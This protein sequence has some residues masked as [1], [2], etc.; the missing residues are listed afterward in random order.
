MLS[1][2]KRAQSDELSADAK[3]A[4]KDVGTLGLS[5]IRSLATDLQVM[6]RRA[7]H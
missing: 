3:R 2:K 1:T 7:C 4:K 6:S 5:A